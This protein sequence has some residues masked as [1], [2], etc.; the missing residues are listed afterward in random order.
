MT[1]LKHLKS[2]WLYYDSQPTEITL[3]L[4]LG[5]LV[6]PVTYLELGFRPVL[7]FM[8]LFAGIFQLY[9]VGGNDPKCREIASVWTLGCFLT[10]LFQYAYCGYLTQS[11]THWGW[12]VLAFSSFG[13]LRRIKMERLSRGK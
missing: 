9:C 7:Q 10:I 11:P 1:R 8:S 4:C 13:T 6:F 2:V 5:V 3:A 12:A